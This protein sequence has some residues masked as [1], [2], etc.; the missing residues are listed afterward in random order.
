MHR[1]GRLAAIG[2]LLAAFLVLWVVA[3]ASAGMDSTGQVP[4]ITVGDQA[5][6]LVGD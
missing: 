3:S 2:W 4:H 1:A 6:L 5:R